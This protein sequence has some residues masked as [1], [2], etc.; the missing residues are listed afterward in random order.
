MT[1]WRFIVALSTFAFSLSPFPAYADWQWTRW[2]MTPEQVIRASRGSAQITSEQEK[3][4]NRRTQHGRT[5]SEALLKS[6]HQAGSLNLIAW[7]LFGLDGRLQCVALQARSLADTI[8][9]E[10]ELRVTYGTPNRDNS[11]PLASL[12]SFQWNRDDII[13]FYQADIL[14]GEVLYCSRG[15][16]GL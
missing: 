8:R 16:G 12:R 9:L 3:T 13:T 2:G 1:G 11:I 6:S 4:S 14:N 5:V 7:F 10:N 15:R